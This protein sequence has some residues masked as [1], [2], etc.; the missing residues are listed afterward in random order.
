MSERRQRIGARSRRRLAAVALLALAGA[1][2]ATAVGAPTVTPAPK[3][4]DERAASP[5]RI[6]KDEAI[7]EKRT[8][9][10]ENVPRT[11]GAQKLAKGPHGALP[12]AEQIARLDKLVPASDAGRIPR[13]VDPV[14]WKALVPQDNEINAARVALG[15][16]LY[17]DTRLS[18]DGTLACATC[19]DVSRSFTDRRPVSEGIADQLGQRNA[20]TTMNALFFQTQFLDGRAPSLEEQAKLPIVNPIEM[21]QPNADATIANITNDA[22]Y[23]RLFQD[24]YGRPVNFDDLARAVA[25]F[26]RTLTFLD[27]PF[28]DFAR[29]DTGAI[30]AKAAEGFAL[31][32]GKARCVSCHMLNPSNPLGTDDRFHNIGVSARKQNFEELADRALKALHQKEGKEGIEAVDRLA[33]ETNL[34]EL[35]RFL[36]TKNRSDIGSF[37][38]S[39][40]RN[41]G[42]TGPYMHDGSMQTLTDVMDHYNRGGEANPFL[43]GGIEPLA[44]SESEIEAVVEFLGTLTDKRFVDEQRTETA[45]QRAVAAK[46]RPF[47]ENQLAMRKVLPFESRVAAQASPVPAPDKAGFQAGK[48]GK[49]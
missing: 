20:P 12:M 38:T 39:Q 15:K 35:G 5:E 43:D 26:E 29:G 46:Q 44:L 40:L 32:N 37:K 48:E 11:E 17:F 7:A 16:K 22:E 33:I 36:V 34:S 23:Q 45:R 3:T 1:W 42:I 18:K 10:Q 6:Q 25:T 8:A 14:V 9:E 24:A 49:R 2:Q 27:A 19:H 21:G 28:D 13:G 47:R 4:G 41:V 31:F 30:S